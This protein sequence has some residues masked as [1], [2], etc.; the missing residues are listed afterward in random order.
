[1]YNSAFCFDYNWAVLL[2]TLI[3]LYIELKEYEKDL[4]FNLKKDLLLRS[5]STEQ[6]Y[7]LNKQQE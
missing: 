6:Q 1:M 3:V 2:I 5:L 7:F 4:S